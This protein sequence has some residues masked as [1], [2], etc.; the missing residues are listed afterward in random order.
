MMSVLVGLFALFVGLL[1]GIWG[2]SDDTL[3]T[4]ALIGA[5]VFLVT[6]FVEPF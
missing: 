2:A 1:A 3:L 6:A 4:I 5:F